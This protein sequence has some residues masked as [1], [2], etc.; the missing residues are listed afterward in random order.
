[1]LR[2]EVDIALVAFSDEGRVEFMQRN[3]DPVPVRALAA[4]MEETIDQRYAIH[5]TVRGALESVIAGMVDDVDVFRADADIDG[6]ANGKSTS[7]IRFDLDD[8]AQ[9]RHH[10]ASYATD[11]RLD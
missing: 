3:F 5:N 11:D 10:H 2:G 4:H 9:F 8:A 7:I 6:L 1:M